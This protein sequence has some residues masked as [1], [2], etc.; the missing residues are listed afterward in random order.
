MTITTKIIAEI[1]RLNMEK[2]MND[3]E[4]SEE[5]GIKY[6]TVRYYRLKAGLPSRRHK[7]RNRLYKRYSVYDARTSDFITEGTAVECAVMLGILVGS[8]YSLVTKTRQGKPVNYEIY[9]IDRDD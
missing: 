3:A 2:E 5:L 7:Y 8:F 1:H 6:G 4:I 9:A